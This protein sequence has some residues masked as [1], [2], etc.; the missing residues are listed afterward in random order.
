MWGR[1]VAGRVAAR[2]G[3][4]L[5]GDAVELTV[6]DGRLVCWK[7]AFAGRLLAAIHTS[8]PIQLATIRPGAMPIVPPRAATD[9]V[10]TELPV[11]PDGRLRV[12]DRGRDDDL[13]VL[14]GAPIVIGIGQGVEASS[15]ELLDP[16]REALGAEFAATRKVTDHG[17]MP[18]ARQLGLTGRA[19]A[20]RLYVAIGLSGKFNHMVGVRSAATVLA[21]NSDADALVFD[22][23]DIGIVGDWREVVPALAEAVAAAG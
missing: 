18:H 16:L 5:T 21:I 22:T 17:W 13:D 7:P 8:S 6:A 4:G 15:Y 23:A 14:P 12:I 20:P 3:A 9:L 11:V 2:L 1:E 10:R 19:I